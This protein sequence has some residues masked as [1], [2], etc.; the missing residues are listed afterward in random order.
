MIDNVNNLQ[1]REKENTGQHAPK[2]IKKIS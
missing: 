2:K 1:I